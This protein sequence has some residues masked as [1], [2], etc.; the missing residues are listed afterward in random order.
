MGTPLISTIADAD[1]VLS[2]YPGKAP[3]RVRTNSTNG[4]RMVN[5]AATLENFNKGLLTPS[6][7]DNSSGVVATALWTVRFDIRF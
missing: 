2:L 7:G 3:Y 6:C 4:H 5:D 1:A